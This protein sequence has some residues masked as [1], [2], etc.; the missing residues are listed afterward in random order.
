MEGKPRPLGTGEIQLIVSRWFSEAQRSFVI[1]T[2]P[3]PYDAE[4]DRSEEAL[5]ASL[6]QWILGQNKRLGKGDYST[7]HPIVER[8]LARAG[9]NADRD[10]PSFGLLCRTLMR[11]WMAIEERTVAQ[12][13]GEFGFEPADLILTELATEEP[14]SRAPNLKTVED[15]ITQFSAEKAAK[16]SPSA[17]RA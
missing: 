12:M 2:K 17:V 9:I 14:T 4:A 13:R 16:W 10:D 8:L 7:L 3:R 6:E 5:M 1:S 11:A 15:L